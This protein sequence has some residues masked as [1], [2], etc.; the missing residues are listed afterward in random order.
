MKKSIAS[1]LCFLLCFCLLTLPV[2]AE[3][4]EQYDNV[5]ETGIVT[6]DED[7]EDF[8]DSA[9]DDS[10]TDP[11]SDETE[12]T[13]EHLP[14][15]GFDGLEPEG[16]GPALMLM[17]GDGPV[18]TYTIT[19]STD[20]N[21]EVSVNNQPIDGQLTVNEGE[22]LNFSI[23][24][25]PGYQVSTIS[26]DG[27]TLAEGEFQINGEGQAVFD[28]TDIQSDHTISISFS[29]RDWIIDISFSINGMMSFPQTVA[30]GEDSEPFTFYPDDGYVIGTITITGDTLGTVD[31]KNNLID[32]GDGTFSVIIEN[33]TEDLLL[34]VTFI[35]A[36]ITLEGVLGKSYA[37]LIDDAN[38]DE[39]AKEALLA[40]M[41]SFGYDIPETDITVSDRI[42]PGADDEFGTFTFTV[43]VNDET[44]PETTGYIVKK[45]DDVLFR[46]V[47]LHEEEIVD[48]IRVAGASDGINKEFEAP[49]M[50]TG[51]M[52]VF[53]VYNARITGLTSPDVRDAFT[54]NTI[55]K[56]FYRA[57]LHIVN[58]YGYPE[59][60]KTL[61]WFAFNLIQEDA[62]CVEVS[63]TSTDDNEKQL[64]LEWELNKYAQLTTGSYTSNVFFGNDVFTL[65]LPA[66]GIGGVESFTV[67]TGEYPGYQVIDN[68]EQTFSVRFFSDFYD[69]VT[70][71]LTINGTE[72]RQLII[73]R[74]GVHIQSYQLHDD[75]PVDGHSV[76]HGTQYA[77]NI[78]YSDGNKYRIYAS[79]NI[80]DNGTTAPYGLYV[81]Y[82]WA[83]GRVTTDIITEPCDDP[84]PAYNAEEYSNGV[85][86]YYNF[87]DC[88]DYL[89]YSAP[90]S[91]NVP[92]RINVLVLKADP[93]AEAD[94]GG[95]YFGSG[96]GVE[97]NLD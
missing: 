19:V 18:V 91:S 2:L 5:T 52:E 93:G 54:G 29:P 4:T 90:S 74:V 82:T 12:E 34:S 21:G 23:T 61:N 67:Q 31:I 37:I 38:T 1:A 73:H 35:K 33:V 77:T 79:Y 48:K 86:H 83:D 75:Q 7:I 14:P 16:N 3:E 51:I 22:N 26:I 76:F 94:F 89:L 80:P 65:S 87:A 96:A 95:I 50:D 24:P 64:T 17:N 72:E 46:F 58:D 8:T 40:E 81:T 68:G 59:T 49:A 41:L 39:K 53:G 88:C 47:G 11:V 9:D 27:E 36:E 69:R 84:S 44:S 13:N 71:D 30:H 78:D 43:T 57:Q 20:G 63:A 28:L 45:F 25:D 10:D 66:S 70:L 6:E 97:W 55:N 32:N 60:D 42:L 62:Y 56:P 85:F 92:V 15:M